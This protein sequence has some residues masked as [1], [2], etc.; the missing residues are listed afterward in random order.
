MGSVLKQKEIALGEG[1]SGAFNALVWS[2]D[3]SAHEVEIV[4]VEQPEGWLVFPQ[5]DRFYIGRDKGP[6]RI[7][8]SSGATISAVPVKIL[9]KPQGSE[10]GRYRIY[11]EVRG[12]SE[13]D[14]VSFSQGWVL[15][16]HVT[17]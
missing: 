1:E 6:E 2:A 12:A 10:P 15:S 17:V 11:V 9:V 14:S 4:V 7:V 3:E 16:L 8:S 13:R 5:P